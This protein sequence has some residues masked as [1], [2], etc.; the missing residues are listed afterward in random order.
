MAAFLVVGGLLAV[1][2]FLVSQ[3]LGARAQLVGQVRASATSTIAAF[4]EHAGGKIVGHVHAFEESEEPLLTAP[5]TGRPCV[6]YVVRV[7]E[8]KSNLATESVDHVTIL[9]EEEGVPFVVTDG[10]GYAIVDPRGARVAL[11]TDAR[12][13]SGTFDDAT[14]AEEQLLQRHGEASVG[15]WFNRA[16]TYHEAVI[17]P[18]ERIAVLGAGVREPDPHAA[19]DG[20]Y[21]GTMPTRLRMSSSPRYPLVISDEPSATQR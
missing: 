1:L 18:G 8:A 21:R 6:Y 2:I 15:W 10:T 11:V 20:G 5:I 14:A 4:P 9:H 13:K 17:A 16:L 7:V 19:P 3:Q 12:T